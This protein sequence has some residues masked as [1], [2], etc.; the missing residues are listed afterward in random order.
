MAEPQKHIWLNG[1]KLP[2]A[3]PI[4][5]RRITPFPAQFS[6]SQPGVEDYTPTRKQ[7]FAKLKG[8]MG[9][10]KW[11]PNSEDRFWDANGVDASKDVQTLGPLVTPMEK[12]DGTGFGAIPVKIIKFKGRIWAIGHDKISYWDGSAWQP[13][14]TDFSNP[15]DAIVYYGTI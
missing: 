10:E 11:D 6:T 14:K 9:Q 12:A 8:G 15:T 2:I 7:R 13:K 5:W 1:Q 4:T 3:S